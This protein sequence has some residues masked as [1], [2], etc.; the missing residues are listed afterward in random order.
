[1]KRCTKCNK[2]KVSSLFPKDRNVCKLCYAKQ[3]ADLQKTPKSKT[4]H[5]KAVLK[6]SKS[7]KGRKVKEKEYE[8]N[9]VIGWDA[10]YIKYNGRARTLK[11]RYNITVEYFNRMLLEQKGLCGICG[12]PETA[13]RKSTS[14]IVRTLQLSVDHNHETGEIRGL[15]CSKCNLAISYFKEDIKYMANAISYIEKHKQKAVVAKK[16]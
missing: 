3:K 10:F 7:K 2:S 16:A 6:Y 4:S 13:T 11:G 5:A 15:L 8:K 12:N 14:G 1:M 9:R